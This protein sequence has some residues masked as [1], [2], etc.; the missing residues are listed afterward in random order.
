MLASRAAPLLRIAHVLALLALSQPLL[1]IVHPEVNGWRPDHAHIELAGRALVPHA[2]P[3]DHPGHDQDASEDERTGFAAPD[4]DAVAAVLPASAGLV[5]PEPLSVVPPAE[6]PL[7]T[8]ASIE[9]D[10]PPPRA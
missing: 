9:T 5:S 1:A 8:D 6:V 2:H 4:F 10:P 7:V 3:Y